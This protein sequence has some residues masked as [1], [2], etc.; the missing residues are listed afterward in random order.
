MV[1]TLLSGGFKHSFLYAWQNAFATRLPRVSPASVPI[2]PAGSPAYSLVLNVTSPP[3]HA[4][5]IGRHGRH[6]STVRSRAGHHIITQLDSHHHHRPA[7]F[8][9]QPRTPSPQLTHSRRKREMSL[10]GVPGTR[11]TEWMCSTAE[12]LLTAC[13]RFWKRAGYIPLS[14]G[15][16]A[17]TASITNVRSGANCW[18]PLFPCPPRSVQSPRARATLCGENMQIVSGREISGVT[19]MSCSL[20]IFA[21]VSAASRCSRFPRA[22]SSSVRR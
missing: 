9:L 20:P 11:R 7:P 1:W 15:Q 19:G 21:S 14:L 4:R 3:P 8:R 10:G 18:F 12:P 22:R 16:S 6:G 5:I 2:L 17:P 13:R